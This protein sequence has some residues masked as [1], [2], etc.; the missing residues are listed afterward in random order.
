M[1]FQAHVKTTPTMKSAY[2]YDFPA[3]ELRDDF[4]KEHDAE[5]FWF[6]LPEDDDM[7]FREF[8]GGPSWSN[9]QAG[10]WKKGGAWKARQEA[11]AED[12]GDEIAPAGAPDDGERW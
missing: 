11:A 2:Q 10:G 9:P 6:F 7:F 1:G 3:K 4:L 8:G 5:I 12:P